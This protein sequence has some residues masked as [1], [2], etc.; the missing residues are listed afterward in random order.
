MATPDS[1]ENNFSNA[2]FDPSYLSAE[3]KKIFKWSVSEIFCQ[4]IEGDA[5]DRSYFRVSFKSKANQKGPQSL[6]IMQLK[7]P[8]SESETDFTRTLQFLRRLDLP[9]PELFHYDVPMGLLFLEECGTQTLED[10]LNMFPEKKTKLYRQAVE[11]LFDMQTRA[12]RM[13][14][15][16]CPAYHLKF[17]VK[18][19]MWEFDFM[20]D[21]YVGGLCV[22]PLESLAK[23]EAREVFSPLCELLAAQK[24]CFT[25]RDFHSRNLMVDK[26]RL[27]LIDFQDARMGPCQ[28]DLVSLLK[29]SYTQIDDSL[30]EEL[31]DL[32]I[33]LKENEEGR[34]VDREEF[35]RIFDGASLQRNLKAVGTFAYQSLKKNNHRYRSYIAPTLGYVR[36]TLNRKYRNSALREALFKYIP[37]LDGNEAV[38]L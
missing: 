6:I 14:D 24:P 33:R 32:Y 5:S 36:Q 22:S 1:S 31:I 17:D 19:L 35:Y 21:H 38:E 8:I 3:V 23:K 25:H 7:D 9:T 12:T 11:L 4:A 29:D 2:R 28:Y 20:L 15:S 26:N 30:I 13:I 37:G 16:K 18:K 10:Q 34:E 27:V